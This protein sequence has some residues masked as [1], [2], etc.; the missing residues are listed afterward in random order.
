MTWVKEARG[1]AKKFTVDTHEY[2]IL[3]PAQSTEIFK[4]LHLA[5]PGGDTR[6]LRVQIIPPCLQGFIDQTEIYLW[7][8]CLNLPI[9][10]LFN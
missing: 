6:P 1:T 3:F 9:E 10:L 8:D 4:L 2:D 7:S 5:A